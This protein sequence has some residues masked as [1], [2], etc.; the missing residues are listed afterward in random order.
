MDTTED[1][2]LSRIREQGL[3]FDRDLCE[4]KLPENI[5]NVVAA[6][7]AGKYHI[8][9]V[10]FDRDKLV[11]VTD[12]EQT[13]MNMGQLRETLRMPVKVLVGSE[14]NIKMALSQYYKIQG[15][16][17]SK[18]I[19]RKDIITEDGPLKRRI[20]E[21]IQNAARDRASDVHLLPFSGGIYVQ[22]RID[23][24]LVDVTNEYEFKAA[25]ALNVVN[26]IKGFDTSNSADP[27]RMYLPDSGSWLIT[28]GEI[29]IFIRMATFPVGNTE[30][31]Q[32]VNLRLLPQ[33]HKI[34]RLDEIGYPK[35]DLKEIRKGLYKFATGLFLNSGPTG[36]GKTT[37]L[38]AQMYD[39]L[40]LAGEPLNIIT[41]DDPIEIREE[42]FS[43]VQVRH[44]ED[45]ALGLSPKKILKV[46]LRSDPDMFLYNEIRDGG[47]AFVAIEASTTGHRVFSTVHAS[48]CI[49]TITRLMDL[50]VSKTSLLSEL[51][52]IISQRLIGILCPYCSKPHTLSEIE[53]SIL[54]D[55]EIE[56]LSAAKLKERG[57]GCPECRH[58]FEGRIAVDEYVIFDNEL[59]DALLNQSSFKQVENILKKRDFKSMWEKGV[60]MV[61]SG[62]VDFKE[63]VRVIGKEE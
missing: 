9:P 51:R 2:Y 39:V 45:T 56:R 1:Y 8:I 34:V 24:H 57:E 43:Q 36:S 32:K 12:A 38:Y 7:I 17:Q 5:I 27:G 48:N 52:M 44:T 60:D 49:K 4:M 13:I 54:T 30:G 35:A 28:H 41:I 37:S 20:R 33:N 19:D 25:E 23:G 47:D 26:I 42:K 46:G 6:E 59:R 22:F 15:Y 40:D 21:L 14:E 53:K 16:H 50:D 31:W 11:L 3:V 58:G 55:T 18:D 63:I 10:C 62:R 61:A 29:P